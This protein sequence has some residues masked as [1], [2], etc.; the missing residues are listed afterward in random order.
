[1]L[2]EFH[3][4]ETASKDLLNGIATLGQGKLPRELV[5]DTRLRVMLKEVHDKETIP[6]LCFG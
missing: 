1:M 5:S 4:L 2:N 3:I 6:R